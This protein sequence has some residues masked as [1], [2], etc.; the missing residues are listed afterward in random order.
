MV[1]LVTLTQDK[2]ALEATCTLLTTQVTGQQGRMVPDGG[3]KGQVLTRIDEGAAWMDIPG[4]ESGVKSIQLYKGWNFVAIPGQVVVNDEYEK[5]LSRLSV[6]TYD[7]EHQA[8]VI[9][10]DKDK[11]KANAGY[12]IYTK[13]DAV[14]HIAIRE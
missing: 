3:S 5:V 13:E 6:F 11:L 2:A 12:W 10:E 9:V 14:L 8:Y 7:R 4:I 1:T